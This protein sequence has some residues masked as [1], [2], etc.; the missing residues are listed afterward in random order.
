MALTM[1]AGVEIAA[2]ENVKTA[3]GDAE[4]FRGLGSRQGAF[5]KSLKHMTNEASGMPVEELLILFRATGKRLSDLRNRNCARVQRTRVL[6][7]DIRSS[8]ARVVEE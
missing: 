2:V 5:A 3:A 7:T 4:L 8:R 6:W 1:S